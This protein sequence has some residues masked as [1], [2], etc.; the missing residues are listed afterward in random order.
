MED[1]YC[2]GETTPYPQF[3]GY[4]SAR[5]MGI[6]L[7]GGSSSLLCSDRVLQCC[8]ISPDLLLDT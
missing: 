1:T 3:T 6:P 4:L 2:F 7:S 8:W 5:S